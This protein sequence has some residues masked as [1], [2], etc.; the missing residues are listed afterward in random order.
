MNCICSLWSYTSVVSLVCV[1]LVHHTGSHRSSVTR[2]TQTTFRRP[3]G[4]SDSRSTRSR[5]ELDRNL[6]I[7]I[8]SRVGHPRGLLTRP[9]LPSRSQVWDESETGVGPEKDKMTVKGP[10]RLDVRVPSPDP[11]LTWYGP[12][13]INLLT[14]IDPNVVSWGFGWGPR[15]LPQLSSQV[16]LC[17][18]CPNDNPTS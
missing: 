5:H 2:G 9:G 10:T 16:V 4:R 18:S 13:F 15:P 17:I 14:G 7:T 12:D 1:V 11:L 3:E 8:F 6:R